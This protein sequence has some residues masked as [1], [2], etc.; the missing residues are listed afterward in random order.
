MPCS[1]PSGSPLSPPP[2]P[3]PV[4]GPG[5]MLAS[6][7]AG[8]ACFLGHLGPGALL[9]GR[10]LLNKNLPP[11]HP[12]PTPTSFPL[13]SVMSVS[14]VEYKFSTLERDAQ[15]RQE[16]RPLSICFLPD[17]LPTPRRA[18]GPVDNNPS[19]ILLPNHELCKALRWRIYRGALRWGPL[20]RGLELS[21]VL[22]E[23]TQERGGGGGREGSRHLGRL[24]VESQGK[25]AERRW[26]RDSGQV[27]SEE[28]GVAGRGREEGKQVSEPGG[29]GR[30]DPE[31]KTE[32][33]E[34]RVRYMRR[35]NCVVSR[36]GTKTN[37]IL[38]AFANAPFTPS[39]GFVCISAWAGRQW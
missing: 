32:R 20:F 11:P 2:T 31:R 22:E 36:K 15:S 30:R 38:L 25:P 6:P 4:P 1:P 17:S 9:S 8:A 13:T 19:P 16:P 26:H 10:A 12:L 28:K 35:E 39:G 21:P 24:R 33:R 29:K 3:T 23:R 5:L 7:A 34:S 27:G 18:A 14:G 37:P